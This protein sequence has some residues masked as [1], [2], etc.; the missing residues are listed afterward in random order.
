[1]LWLQFFRDYVKPTADDP[2]A[3]IVD[4]H[5]TRFGVP[6]LDFCRDNHILLFLLPPNLTS[7]LS[8]SIKACDNIVSSCYLLLQVLD[9][10]LHGPLRNALKVLLGISTSDL[11]KLAAPRL[12]SLV[13]AALERAFTRDNIASGWQATHL[14]TLD[15]EPLIATLRQ[16]EAAQQEAKQRWQDALRNLEEQKRQ[17]EEEEQK[18]AAEGKSEQKAFVPD[19]IEDLLPIPDLPEL[20]TRKRKRP[21]VEFG[22]VLTSDER[23]EAMKRYEA[24]RDSK[25]DDSGRRGRKQSRK[26]KPARPNKRSRRHANWRLINDYDDEPAGGAN[27]IASSVSEAEE[28]TAEETPEDEEL[29]AV[30]FDMDYKHNESAEE[31]QCSDNADSE[32]LGLCDLCEDPVFA[33]SKTVQC[34]ACTRLLHTSCAGSSRVSTRSRSRDYRCPAC[35]TSAKSM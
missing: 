16:N 20:K 24:E 22:G 2:V 1:M 18:A 35:R 3:L 31:A 6:V 11:E 7:K 14:D 10:S 32:Q 9:V 23:Y 4:Q 12:A 25:K 34:S 19:G 29:P 33:S 15:G 30:D 13:Q 26:R 21:E 28:S 17:H 5:S 27:P 8:V